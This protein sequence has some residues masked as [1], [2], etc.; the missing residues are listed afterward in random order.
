M[1]EILEANIF[2]F[3]TA[4][5]VVVLSVFLAIALYY[6]IRILKNVREI[7]DHLL[8]GT[9]A[10]SEDLSHLRSSIKEEA[11]EIGSFFSFLKVW[12]TWFPKKKVRRR[13]KEEGEE[14]S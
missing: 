9:T 12:K 4:V 14:Q 2:F 10:L 5:A 1:S 6:L 13:R 11:R 3:I 8:R 7:S